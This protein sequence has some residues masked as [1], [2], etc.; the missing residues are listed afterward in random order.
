M[1]SIKRQKLDAVHFDTVSITLVWR[2]IDPR[3]GIVV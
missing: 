2:S 3:K 1:I